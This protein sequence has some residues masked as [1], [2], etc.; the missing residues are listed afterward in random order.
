MSYTYRWPRPAVAA[1][2]AVFRR[3]DGALEVLLI[4][5]RNEPF[6]GRWCLPGGFLDRDEAADAAA[7]RELRE[8]TGLRLAKLEQVHAFS[9]PGRD[10]RGHVISIT[11]A[12]LLRGKSAARSGSDAAGVGWFDVDRLP[13]LG[14]DHERA[15]AFAR[16]KLGLDG[17]RRR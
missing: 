3:R 9:E 1:D 14:F 4:Q 7:R 6:K 16:A 13:P 8:E 5:R 17:R 12:A 11:H 2:I 15:I 10:P